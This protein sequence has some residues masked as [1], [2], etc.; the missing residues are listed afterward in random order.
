M[1][2]MLNLVQIRPFGLSD[3]IL[4]QPKLNANPDFIVALLDQS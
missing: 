1:L 2:H 3:D 4:E